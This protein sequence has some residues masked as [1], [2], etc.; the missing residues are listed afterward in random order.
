VRRNLSPGVRDPEWADT[1]KRNNHDGDAMNIDPSEKVLTGK[2]IQQGGRIVADSVS[3][4]IFA[5]TKSHLIEVGKNSSGWNILYRDPGDGR[6]WELT[7][8]QG[9]LHGGGPPHLNCITAADAGR[10]YGARN[11]LHVKA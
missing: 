2:W 5:L 11:V 9:D 6:L 8:P 1:T 10:K 7:Y 4:R 3:D